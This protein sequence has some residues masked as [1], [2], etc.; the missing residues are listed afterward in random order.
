MI[1]LPRIAFLSSLG[2]ET[3]LMNIM[4]PRSIFPPL[5]TPSVYFLFLL[6]IIVT[7]IIISCV[8]PLY[9]TRPEGLT[10]PLYSLGA[11]LFVVL[12]R[13]TSSPYPEASFCAVDTNLYL[14]ESCW[15]DNLGIFTEGNL[16]LYYIS[17][18]TWGNQ[19]GVRELSSPYQANFWR[20]CRGLKST[21]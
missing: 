12:C 3:S 1:C 16:R 21:R 15:F 7:T 10:T 19:R 18:S 4:G 13:S 2:R 8:D 9:T 6:S 20:R 14:L 17:P 5:F 11:K